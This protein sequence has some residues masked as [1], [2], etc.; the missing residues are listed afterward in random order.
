MN[1]LKLFAKLISGKLYFASESRL[2]RLS[3]LLIVS[4]L[5]LLEFGCTGSEPDPRQDSN[6][7]PENS[8][9]SGRASQG[10]VSGSTP[11]AV[12]PG[13]AKKDMSEATPGAVGRTTLDSSDIQV[14]ALTVRPAE[15]D[16]DEPVVVSVK[17][18]NRGGESGREKLE[19]FI[20]GDVARTE[21]VRVDGGGT[22]TVT[23]EIR[24]ED[25]RTY[26]VRVGNKSGTFK[27]RPAEMAKEPNDLVRVGDFSVALVDVER[28]EAQTELVFAISKVDETG[29]GPRFLPI[30]L[31][32]D[33][34]GEYESGYPSNNS[35]HLGLRLDMRME[36]GGFDREFANL[37]LNSLPIGFVYVDSVWVEIPRLAPIALI[38]VGVEQVSFRDV[39]LARPK[40]PPRFGERH[41]EAGDAVSVGQWLSFAHGAIVSARDGWEVEIE[42]R[43]EDYT[44][45]E[46]GVQLGLLLAE[47]R[48]RWAS[49]EWGTAEAVSN[50]RMKADLGLD[51]ATWPT[52]ELRALIL[53]YGGANFGASDVMSLAITPI[54]VEDLPSLVGQGLENPA[55]FH[56]A[57]ERVGG[58]DSIGQPLGPPYW[59]RGRD[60]P[61]DPIDLMVQEFPGLPNIGPSAFIWDEQKDS[62]QAYVLHPAVWERYKQLGGPYHSSS[63]DNSRL[64]VPTSDSLRNSNDP[65]DWVSR[66]EGGSLASSSGEVFTVMGAIN[67]TWSN[68]EKSGAVHFGLPTG[69]AEVAPVSGALGFQTEGWVQK[70]ERGGHI[71]GHIYYHATGS[72]AGESFALSGGLA[73]KFDELGGTTSRLG[74]PVSFQSSEVTSEPVP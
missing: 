31:L 52:P 23:F 71:E 3:F 5:F 25:A 9:E 72:H 43:N 7:K 16:P 61:Y 28:E 64:G 74:F 35:G 70:F 50:T 68:F 37:L 44:E 57:Y 51:P 59:L 21:T 13:P 4:G 14:T 1:T 6:D 15:V 26:T 34:G 55:V 67:D 27:V 56:S 40:Y 12:A 33:H 63:F 48:I 69:D 45:S 53:L 20:D 32:D 19:L 60:S 38:Q 66:F 58:E 62:N 41:V 73:A 11:S 10:D 54:S 39:E 30:A 47:G 49:P 22:R 36:D 65:P 8:R 46:V 24:P 42:V 29:A 17:V 18:A 2:L